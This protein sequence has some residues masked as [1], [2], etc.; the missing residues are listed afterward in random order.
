[1]RHQ[2][3]NGIVGQSAGVAALCVFALFPAGAFAGTAS[4]RIKRVF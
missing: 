3:P 4:T 2:R 1:M